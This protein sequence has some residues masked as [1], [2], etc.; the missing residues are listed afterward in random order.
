[1]LERGDT[2]ISS[3]VPLYA[4][5]VPLS[6]SPTLFQQV[7]KRERERKKGSGRYCK[8]ERN[9]G[10]K[11]KV[12]EREKVF[13]LASVVGRRTP[14]SSLARPPAPCHA[15]PVSLTRVYTGQLLLCNLDTHITG[16]LHNKLHLWF[17]IILSRKDNSGGADESERLESELRHVKETQTQEKEK[18]LFMHEKKASVENAICSD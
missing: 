12:E 14:C 18:L 1:M 2:K 17:V 10:L 3:E 9:A 8:E 6:L 16:G 7:L 4:R 5:F 13:S 15:T 11:R